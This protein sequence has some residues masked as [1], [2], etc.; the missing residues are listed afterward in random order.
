[1][2]CILKYYWYISFQLETISADIAQLVELLICNQRTI[3]QTI[4][5]YLIKSICYAIYFLHKPPLFCP[6]ERRVSEF[7]TVAYNSIHFN[8]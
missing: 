6:S 8:T 4:K 1:M 5:K 3:F 2:Y 7:N